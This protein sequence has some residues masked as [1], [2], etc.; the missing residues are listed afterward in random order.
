MQINQYLFY[1]KQNYTKHHHLEPE[2]R[3][4]D[5]GAANQLNPFKWWG[6]SGVTKQYNHQTGRE[7][8]PSGRE[9]INLA[10]SNQ[11]KLCG[12]F[13]HYIKRDSPAGFLNL[14]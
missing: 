7:S 13:S 3:N 1:P 9:F 12:T 5:Q 14:L 8:G 2:W 6:E 11:N 10:L 4:K